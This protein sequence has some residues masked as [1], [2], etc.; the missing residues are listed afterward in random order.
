MATGSTATGLTAETVTIPGVAEPLSLRLPPEVWALRERAL[1]VQQEPQPGIPEITLAD[2]RAWAAH[3]PEEDWL[4][5]RARR[6]AE[7]LRSL[8]VDLEPGERV[9]GKPRLRLPSEAEAQE[10]ARAQEILATMPPFP[11]GDA[12]LFHPDYE[13]LFR[14]GVGG[15]IAC[16]SRPVRRRRAGARTEVD[17][18]R[19][20]LGV[21]EEQDTFYRACRIA[22]E[23]LADFIR[24]T[25]VASEGM[26]AEDPER[27]TTWRELAGICRR[28]ALEPPG[29]FREAI[30]LLFLAE[31]AL[32]FGEDHGLTTPGRLDQTLRPY[33]EAD[34]GFGRITRQE[35]FELLCCLYI[36]MNRILWPGSAVSVLVGGRDRP[37]RDVTNEL[38]YL[39]LAARQATRLVYPTVGLA[40]HAGTPGELMDFAVRMLASGVGDPAFFNDEVISAGLRDHGVAPE[41]AHHYMNSTCVEIKVVGA[42]NMWVTAP[43][44]N[45]PQGLLEVMERVT[46]GDEAAP[47]TFEELQERVRG[48]LGETIRSAAEHL[49]R[50]WHERSRTGWRSM[51]R[52]RLRRSPT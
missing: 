22:L 23:G 27:E 40:W 28:V 37:G 42:S 30:Q 49:D 7:R 9:V 52:R 5:W 21:T 25:A 4:L 15:L 6:V 26:A 2:A 8:P 17:A 48:R 29:T 11:G 16:S 34:L 18:R 36:Q 12:G 14:L 50:V 19:G 10:L 24:R 45:L 31:I 20:A 3:T 43:Y 33:Y 32:W 51:T 38:T 47:A 35:A 1:A 44:F 41:D 39:C 46:K 13:K